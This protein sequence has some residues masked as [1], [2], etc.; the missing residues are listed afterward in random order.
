MIA[1]ND[2]QPD[3]GLIHPASTFHFDIQDSSRT[4]INPN[5]L[6]SSLDKATRSIRYPT[7]AAFYD[8]FIDTKCRTLFPAFH[9]V[10]KEVKEENRA[11]EGFRGVAGSQSS[12]EVAAL[13]RLLVK[14]ARMLA[15]QA[16]RNPLEPLAPCQ[17]QTRNMSNIA[18]W[19]R[20]CPRLFDT[21]EVQVQLSWRRP[22]HPTILPLV[23]NI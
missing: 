10:L 16:P 20:H 2:N 17:S 1:W 8:S 9:R 4:L 12:Y 11:E 6:E 3:S 5:L 23:W 14:Q 15:I 21:D 13:N 18:P 7:L 22:R 19:S